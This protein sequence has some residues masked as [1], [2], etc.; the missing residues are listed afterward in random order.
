MIA[1][2]K[3]LLMTALIGLVAAITAMIAGCSTNPATGR[4]QLAFFG[5][6]WEIDIGQQAAPGLVEEFGGEV[7]DPELRAYVADIG[8]RLARHTEADYPSLPWTF[9]LLDSDVINA[10][11]LPG[12]KVF[13][14]RGLAARMTDEAQ[15]AGVLGHEIGHVTARHTAERI[16]QVTLIQGAVQIAGVAADSAGGSG[17]GQ[18]LPAL[19]VGGQLVTLKFGRDQE[20]EADSLGLRYM[21]KENYNPWAMLK[22]MEILKEASSGEGGSEWMSTHPLPE[23]RIQRIT[24]E[25]QRDYASTKDNEQYQF[26]EQRYRDRF[27]RRLAQLPPPADSS[28]ARLLVI[29]LSQPHTWCAH[30]AMKND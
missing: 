18:L 3:H 20:S 6:D 22:V 21:Y 15:M 23:T 27:L 24:Q 8:A 16:S 19:N 5:R 13:F 1:T 14:S 4:S 26:H 25:L 17:A 11:A 12:G 9:T 28:A 29:D 2:R 30:C 7:K 10:F